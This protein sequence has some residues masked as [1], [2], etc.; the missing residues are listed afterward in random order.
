MAP[1]VCG[2]DSK[3][4]CLNVCVAHT[5]D[6]KAGDPAAGSQEV[7]SSG[8]PSGKNELTCVTHNQGDKKKNIAHEID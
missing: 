6:L 8:H 3:I 1:W 4:V 5:Q 7:S 2:Y